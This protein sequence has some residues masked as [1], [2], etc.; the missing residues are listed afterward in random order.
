V[1]ALADTG[2]PGLWVGYSMG[3]R[4]ALGVA[5][6]HPET[7]RALVLVSA[8]AGLTTEAERHARVLEDDHRARDVETRGVEAFL[9]DWLA[10]PMFASVP[11]NAPGLTDRRTLSPAHL[12]HQ[13]R[14]LGPGHMPSYW[15]ALHHL[16]IPVLLVTGSH[17]AKFTTLAEH[18][19]ECLP[20]RRHV[21][22]E[23]GHALPLEAP[24]AL[25]KVVAAFAHERTA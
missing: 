20:D 10:Q 17:D 3:G 19:S 11:P 1:D 21:V 22:L 13:L 23:G 12:A 4:L 24:A 9:D 25:A 5:I 2:G 18:M 8:T 14:A 15:D 6:R 7:V 16:H